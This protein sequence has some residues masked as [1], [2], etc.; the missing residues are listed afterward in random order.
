MNEN[1]IAAVATANGIG[2]VGIIRI[3]GANSKTIADRV[4]KS[5]SDKKIIDMKGYT[6]TYGKVYDG[7]ELIDEAVALV[8]TAPHSYTGE[9]VVEISC[10]GGMYV[11]K[12]VLRAVLKNGAVSAEA[13]EFTKRAFLNGKMG[14]TEAESVMDIISARGAQSARAALSCMDG[15][16]RKR[17]D[18]VCNKLVTGAA[19]LSAW[20][21]YPED[22][23]PEVNVDDLLK[24]LEECKNE[25]SKLLNQYDAGK[26][27]REGVNTVI[28]GR[29]NVGKS[30]LMNL[31]SGC[32]RSI[33]TN[34]P[35]TTRDIIEET[36]MLGEIPLNLSD[37]AGIRCTDDPVESIGVQKAKERVLRAGLVFA[38]FDASQPLSDDDKELIELLKD[39][40]ALAVINKTDLEQKLD[41]DFIR[42]R[43]KHI[44]YISALSGNGTE[45]I[46][47]E[48]ADI[49]GTANLD[50]S[51]GILATERQ[52]MAAETALNSVTEAI[53][54]INIGITLDAVT[55][56]IEDAINSL[57]ELTGERVTEKV[58][59]NVFSHFC[60]GK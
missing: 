31:L 11:T 41:C 57:L 9:D 50:A 10:H 35:G 12:R 7:D 33:V 30:T 1:T 52:R 58:V 25:L 24:S 28:A 56:V 60:V 21:D 32:E 42:Q 43:I 19:H 55:V 16:L 2:G 15:T 51:E 53:D 13:G 54:I 27:I 49:V 26:V 59:D 22:E 8:F 48:V 14:L 46:E 29:P 40:P 36:V 3:S 18:S 34:I 4:F 47:R 39:A 44:V 5:V 37:T 23:I 17:I 38:V 20:A 45:E 6:A